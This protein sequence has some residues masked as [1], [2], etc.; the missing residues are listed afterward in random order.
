MKDTQQAARLFRAV[1]HAETIHAL[2]H[3]R[4]AGEVSLNRGE[5]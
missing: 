2:N 4:V 5:P 1:A 3:F